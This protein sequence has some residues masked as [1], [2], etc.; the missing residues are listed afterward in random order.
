MKK[1][2]ILFLMLAV[3]LG[4]V[5]FPALSAPSKD[6]TTKADA[7]ET[8]PSEQEVKPV[9]I[10]TERIDKVGKKIGTEIDHMSK[11]ATRQFG[12]WINA[13]A[14]LGITWIKLM[15]CVF[16]LLAIIAVERFAHA[17]LQSWIAR[18]ST[19]S[20]R[21]SVLL[22]RAFSAPVSLLILLYGSYTALSPLFVHFRKTEEWRNVIDF[23]AKAVEI[24]A[25]LAIAW[26]LNRLVREIDSQV[27][28]MGPAEQSTL[29]ILFKYGRGPA[30]LLVALILLRAL[31]PFL[32]NLPPAFTTFV[33]NSFAVALI[34]TIAWLAIRAGCAME[35]FLLRSYLNESGDLTVRKLRTQVRFLR[36]FATTLTVVLAAASML[37][38]FDK[39]RQ[40]GA[41]V[42]A[43]A[44]ILGI[45]AG[46]AAQRSIG[47]VLV[48]L[49]IAVSQP[50]RIDDVVIIEG[51]WGTVE[52][53]TSTY[54]VIRIWDLR[55][56]IVPLGY[57]IE[58]PFQNWT[59]TSTE[60]LGTVYLY[61]DYSIPVDS[62]REELHRVL[63]ATGNWDG[64][65]WNLQVT[66][67]R[68]NVLE[69]RALMSAAN[70]SNLWDLRCQVRE[71]LIAFVKEAFPESLPRF[72]AEISP[73]GKDGGLLDLGSSP[74]TGTVPQPK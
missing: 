70:A 8:P 22:G 34:G 4:A 36:R 72:R 57:F 11:N 42:L 17:R 37:M 40:L 38:L 46:F 6:Q 54:A 74:V 52:E 30:K 49:Q 60:L 21:W 71:K 20:F 50:I 19:G 12:G 33:A 9:P 25:A 45:V 15:I 62:V 65:V 69:L 58:K 23:S 66:D 10:E 26:S 14:F 43:S 56:L 1:T 32:A 64:K 13:K 44:G 24:G 35:D 41:G 27:K 28:K 67:A 16:L 3:L 2:T 51:E 63:Q 18:N 39:V 68:E 7:Q 48:G 31:L 55:R 73:T 5:S 47:N 61:T 29:G 59:R 53:I